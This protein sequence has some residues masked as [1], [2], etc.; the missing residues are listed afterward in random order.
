VGVFVGRGAA[1]VLP[2]V[3][4][5]L[6]SRTLGLEAMGW[7]ASALATS[8]AIAEVADMLSQR[9]VVRVLAEDSDSARERV[10][11]FNALRLL[12]FAAAACVAALAWAGAGTQHFLVAAILMAAGWG[13]VA[14]GFYAQA[15][16]DGRFAIVGTG[17]LVS[18]AVAVLFAVLLSW[19]TPTLELWNLV[20]A[21]HAGR[22]AELATLVGM[23]RWPGLRW[24]IDGLVEQFRSASYLLVVT[25]LSAAYV[26]LTIPVTLA[27]AGR[28]AS[29]LMSIGLNLT[30]AVSITVVALTVPAYRRAVGDVAPSSMRVAF[31]RTRSDFAAGLLA[32]TVI[33]AGLVAVTPQVLRHI[34]HVDQ[35]ESALVVRLILLG[36]LFEA[37]A[38]FGGVYYHACYRDR[39][40]SVVSVVSLIASWVLIGVAGRTFGALGL[41]W[42]F[43][44]SRAATVAILYSPV[45]VSG[46]R[47]RTAPASTGG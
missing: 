47:S 32:T 1:G 22:L 24:K 3:L 2:L 36:G 14:N 35:P 38:L 30:A 18:L 6:A 41:G 25:L 19:V 17:P 43:L 40:L 13:V 10:A 46:M 31:A 11:S 7:F 33:V 42:G 9:Q 15:I 39:L 44:V 28:S 16:A 23:V 21:L 34:F 8:Y 45:W 20:I 26:R 12:I 27:I 4:T 37:P 5:A 29:G